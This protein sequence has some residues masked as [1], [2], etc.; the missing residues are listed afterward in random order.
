MTE[1]S[2][3]TRKKTDNAF[4]KKVARKT[5]VVVGKNKLDDISLVLVGEKKIQE[6]NE[7]Y[8]HKNKPTDVLSFEELN[9]IFIC[10]DV[11]KKQAKELGVPYKNELARVLIHGILHLEGFDHEKGGKE[12]EKMRKLEEKII[13]RT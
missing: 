8:R 6:I 9:E 5:I 11:V 2:N 7:K 12:A 4:L 3:L 13:E 1:I 10:P